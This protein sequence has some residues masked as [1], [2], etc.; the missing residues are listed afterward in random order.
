[1]AAGQRQ[2]ALVLTRPVL[3]GDRLTATDLR[4][5]SVALDGA[6][7]AVPAAE[8]ATVIGEPVAVSLPAGALLPRAALGAAPRPPQGRAVAALALDPGQAPRDVA[9]GAAVLVVLTLDPTLDPAAGTAYPG[10]GW[11]GLVTSVVDAPNGAGQVVSVE[12]DSDD[13]SR[14]AATP[15]GRLS[16][17]VVAGGDR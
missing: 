5:A 7:D 8:A 15:A 9:P 13:A 12:L 10:V 16:L 14:V 1:M 6:V 4:E 11:E 2:A 3:V 17:L